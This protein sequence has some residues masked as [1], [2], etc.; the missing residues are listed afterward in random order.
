MERRNVLG[1]TPCKRERELSGRRKYP[2]GICPDPVFSSTRI[3]EL[4]PVTHLLFQ[5]FI[6]LIYIHRHRKQAT[7]KVNVYH[8]VPRADRRLIIN[9]GPQ[10]FFVY[11]F[12]CNSVTRVTHVN[13]Y[14]NPDGTLRVNQHWYMYC[15]HCEPNFTSM[16]LNTSLFIAKRGKVFLYM[17]P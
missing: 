2:G 17:P 1:P 11:N 5:P 7:I 8:R 15:N 3:G 16:L 9:F 12:V 6:Q 10:C 13:A 14:I 4:H